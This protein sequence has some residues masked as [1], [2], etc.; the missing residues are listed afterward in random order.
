MHQNSDKLQKLIREALQRRG[1]KPAPLNASTLYNMAVPKG[2][3]KVKS[4]RSNNNKNVQEL[5]NEAYKGRNLLDRVR[6]F[7]STGGNLYLTFGGVGDLVLLLGECYNDKSAKV[8]FFANQPS[9]EFA[10]QFVSFFG[11]KSFISPNI[12][13]S[14]L[15]NQVH[16]VL[17]KTGRLKNS[18]HL[19]KNLDYGDWRKNAYYYETKIKS[20]TTW[21]QDIGKLEFLNNAKVLILAPCGSIRT[22]GKQR[23]LTPE[24]YIA[25]T[26]LYLSKGWIVYSVGSEKDREFYPFLRNSNHMWL[27]SDKTI[28][29]N[30][31]INKHSFDIFLRTINSAKEVISVDTWL[32]TYTLLAGLPTKVIESKFHGSYMPFG[33]DSSD[34]VFINPNIWK[35]IKIVRPE[36]II[37]NAENL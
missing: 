20:Q 8:F 12:M 35:N 3:E 30:N 7:A 34:Y 25:I 10:N 23:Y 11:L 33:H 22:Q 24:E 13:G 19:A 1:G 32:K 15:A 5:R 6:H 9:V 29:E 37:I 4:I 21:F 14:R 17:E 18:A 36:N 27:M 16:D 28:N 2:V 31:V 26:N